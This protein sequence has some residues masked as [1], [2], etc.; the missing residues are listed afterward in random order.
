MTKERAI[1]KKI[2][3]LYREDKSCMDWRTANEI[4]VLLDQPSTPRHALDSYWDSES[5][6]RGYAEAELKLKKAHGIGGGE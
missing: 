3:M 4:Q 5:Y 2:L 6:Q 1:L